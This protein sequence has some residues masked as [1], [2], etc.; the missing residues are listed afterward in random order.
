[1]DDRVIFCIDLRSFFAAVECADAGLDLY[2][3]PLVVSDRRRGMGAITLAVT[4]FL[5]AKGIPSRIARKCMRVSEVDAEPREESDAA[6]PRG[7]R[8]Q[9]TEHAISPSAI[10]PFVLP[11]VE[12]RARPWRTESA[13]VAGATTASMHWHVRSPIRPLPTVVVSKDDIYERRRYIQKCGRSR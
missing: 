3:V 11:C 4:P 7:S 9:N 12:F 2:E 13:M 1:M 10:S 8:G 6:A 5:K